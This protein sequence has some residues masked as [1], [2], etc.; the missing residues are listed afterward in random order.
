MRLRLILIALIIPSVAGCGP[1][2]ASGPNAV[3]ASFYPLAFAAEQIAP[4][5][6]TVENL[7]PPGAEPHDLEVSPSDAA[8]LRD[9]GHVLLLG[10]G[11]QPQLE[12][13]AGSGD[14]VVDLLDTPGLDLL[15]DGDPHVWLDPVRYEKIATRIGEKLGRQEAAGKLVLR[16]QKLDAE[17]RAG[18]AHCAHREI[19]TS[20]EAFAYLAQRYGLEQIP[21]TGISPE[22]EPQ[23]GDLVRVGQLAKERGA[24]TIYFETLVSPRIAQTVAREIGAKTAVL[25]PIEGLTK[26]EAARGDDYFTLMHANLR[27]LRAGLGCR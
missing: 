5:G 25:D 10:H 3:A 24:T 15:P 16:L 18:L 9:A 19:V 20:H 13:A 22:A 12:A 6:D 8:A 1:S 27:A 21:I 4:P 23:P 17:Y 11:F 2:V 14:N 26:D 7:T